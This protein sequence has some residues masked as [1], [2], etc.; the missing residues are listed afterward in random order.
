MPM[1]KFCLLS[2]YSVNSPS[3]PLYLAVFVESQAGRCY[4]RNPMNRIRTSENILHFW[5]FGIPTLEI[6]FVELPA[7]VVVDYEHGK[8]DVLNGVNAPNDLN[9]KGP[10]VPSA[11]F[12][13][14]K[15]VNHGPDAHQLANANANSV[16]IVDRL[17]DFLCGRSP[18]GGE[19]KPSDLY[20]PAVFIVGVGLQQGLATLWAQGGGELLAKDHAVQSNN[21]CRE[22]QPQSPPPTGSGRRSEFPDNVLVCEGLLGRR[23]RRRCTVVA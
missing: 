21:I 16:Q 3:P 14:Y 11:I 19:A 22:P 13:L 10:D 23:R 12:G 18:L 15:H 5:C 17:L 1:A 9:G 8:I 20:Q 7:A 4:H 6:P 2:L